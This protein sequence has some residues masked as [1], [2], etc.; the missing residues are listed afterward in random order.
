MRI[1]Y[2]ESPVGKTL[3]LKA[4]PI[5]L[6][7][8]ASIAYNL[9]DTFFVAKL[10]TKE[11]AAMSFCF[12]IVMII[13]TMMI[14]LSTGINSLASRALG[15]K[16]EEKARE[17]SKKG[18]QLTFFLS[19]GI[20]L[21]GLLTVRPL[22]FLLG[23][24]ET[25]MPLVKQYM[26]IW[27][28]G[29]L[30]TNL[31]VVGNAIFRSKGNV[32]Y[33]SVVLVIGACLNAVL[34]PLLIF[35]YGP[36]PALGISGA[37]WTTVLGNALSILLIFR[38]LAKEEQIH[39]FSLFQIPQWPLAKTILAIALPTA[40]ANC[41]TPL[42]S[43]VTNRMLVHYGNAAVAA[44]SIATRVETVPFIAIFALG[45][46]LGP[47]IGQNWGA[48]QLDR[49]QD[50]IK[51]AF[52][53]TYA[54]GALFALLLVSQRQSIAAFFD[55]SESVVQITS[56]YFSIIPLT[57]AILGTIFLTTH[58]MNAIGRAFL[59]NLLF[60]ARLIFLYLPLAYLLEIPFGIEGIFWARFIANWI[61]GIFGTF[62]IYRVFFKL[63]N[64]DLERQSSSTAPVSK[65]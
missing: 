17:I 56:F 32:L 3:F 1:N 6:G 37:A 13:L 34:D 36:I 14:G 21:F 29:V 28:G 4:V 64:Q 26:N 12:P 60:A 51:K 50:G 61:V 23:V 42:S 15:E 2:L 48:K 35:G 25:L 44:N 41:L 58:A 59:G 31:A 5:F 52:L 55:P 30:F 63:S 8:A 38:K 7:I 18:L 20:T 9:V 47:F 54:L 24:D 19:I 33:P 39:P 10:G 27:Y 11:L 57:Y 43:A 62:M 65:L 46:I 49:I 16:Q 45:F 40:L 53:F 22:F